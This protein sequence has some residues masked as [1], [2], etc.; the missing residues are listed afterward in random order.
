H[1]GDDDAWNIAALVLDLAG[2]GD[3]PSAAAEER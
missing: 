3:W 1:R 2:R